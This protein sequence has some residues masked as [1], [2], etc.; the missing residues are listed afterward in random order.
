M[1]MVTCGHR[2]A[3]TRRVLCEGEDRGQGDAL[4][5]PR[6]WA[7]RPELGAHPPS[8]QTLSHRL[9]AAAQVSGIGENRSHQDPDA[10]ALGPSASPPCVP[11]SVTPHPHGVPP[12]PQSSPLHPLD[13]TSTGSQAGYK[14]VG[15]R[16]PGCKPLLRPPERP[17]S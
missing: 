10:L 7:V 2:H 14:T 4:R 1:G 8:T 6:K 15:G 11:W 12:A 16:R 3:Q 9:Q 5:C 17:G 13:C